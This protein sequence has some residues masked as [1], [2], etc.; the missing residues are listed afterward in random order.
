MLWWTLRALKSRNPRRRVKAA[1]RL[2]ELRDPRAV[3]PLVDALSIP[4]QPGFYSHA[5]AS[6]AEALGLIGDQQ[7]VE[8]LV[9]LLED[10]SEEVCIKAVKALGRIMGVG[11]LIKAT[12]HPSQDVRRAAHRTLS[13]DWDSFQSEEATGA[14][15]ELLTALRNEVGDIRASAALTLSNIRPRVYTE[16]VEPLADMLRDEEP[17]VRLASARAL[18]MCGDK[19]AIERL[20]VALCDEEDD[21]RDAA[22][23]ALESIADY[24]LLIDKWWKSEGAARAVPELLV[25]LENKHP[26]VRRSIASVLGKIGDPCSI[27]VLAAA[28][29]DSESHVRETAAEAL[30][31][32]NSRQAAEVLVEAF[33][34][35]E[36]RS[37]AGRALKR[38]SKSI[39]IELLLPLLRNKSAEVRFEAITLLESAGWKPKDDAQRAQHAVARRKWN[40]AM[41]LG[42]AAVESLT[43]ALQGGDEYV[44][45]NAAQA[46]GKIGGPSAVEPLV[47]AFKRG[48]KKAYLSGGTV[49]TP[50]SMSSMEWEDLVQAL[51]ESGDSQAVKPLL[52][53]LSDADESHRLR[54]ADALASLGWQPTD[55]AEKALWAVAAMRLSEVVELGSAAVEPLVF[56]L[57]T[58]IADNDPFT[59]EA[60]AQ[61]L[62]KIGDRLAV[63][64]LQEA[65]ESS[66]RSTDVNAVQF[67][68]GY[69]SIIKD[70]VQA[71]RRAHMAV[72]EALNKITKGDPN[73]TG[74][75]RPLP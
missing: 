64:P 69:A 32:M 72:K 35:K 56:V 4:D 41:K 58:A 17:H 16:A 61:A 38:M 46:L 63:G 10:A 44:R 26:A 39:V 45:R 70:E 15:P 12:I 34:R 7:A 62:G 43:V 31:N 55:K 27:D 66:L 37:K 40:E 54:A 73:K 49:V 42:S 22:K 50:Q 47:A 6:M 53:V 59:V 24:E 28:L 19:S 60:V 75:R 2:R 13:G 30:A 1:R 8:P 48:Y 3:R 5:R 65:L 20:V 67:D 36:T 74:K 21:V 14:V 23:K 68:D 11:Y 18:S 25:G 51:G 29:M 71:E 33:K 57:K 9:A 52:E